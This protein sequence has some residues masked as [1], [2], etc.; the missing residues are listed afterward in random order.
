MWQNTL[1]TI[2]ERVIPRHSYY[3]RLDPH[4]MLSIVDER[5]VTQRSTFSA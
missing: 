3:K 1:L 2:K 4:Q 5:S